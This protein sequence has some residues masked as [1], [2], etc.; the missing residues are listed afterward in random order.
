METPIWIR[1]NVQGL[2]RVP[3]AFE[4]YER[5]A[6]RPRA[7]C[8]VQIGETNQNVSLFLESA[9]SVTP[10]IQCLA[11]AKCWLLDQEAQTQE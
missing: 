8:V 10:I 9:A 4:T 2:D 5:N 1:T 11:Q 6:D 3:V 7:F